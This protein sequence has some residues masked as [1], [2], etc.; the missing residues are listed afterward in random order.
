MVRASIAVVV[1]AL[2]AAT[3]IPMAGPARAADVSVTLIAK[4]LSWNVGSETSGV[5]TIT[6]NVGDTLRLRVENHDTTLHTFTANQFPA[7]SNQGGSGPFLNVTMTPGRVFFW[8]RTM[9][10]ADAGTWQYYCIPHS[11]GTYPNRTNMVGAIAVVAPTPP[12]S[13]DPLLIGIL[14]LVVVLIGAVVAVAMRRRRKRAP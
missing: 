7:E 11:F 8:N 13:F 9:A 14:L 10:A 5:R 4:N 2:F 3:L 12:I 1:F 6:V